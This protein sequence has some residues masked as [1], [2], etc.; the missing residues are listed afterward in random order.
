V[1]TMKRGEI[2]IKTS[3]R[4]SF[5]NPNL[6]RNRNLWPLD[7]GERRTLK[8]EAQGVNTPRRRHSS[9]TPLR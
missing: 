8:L 5:L 6:A 7:S 1:G 4:G 3:G 2:K 9:E